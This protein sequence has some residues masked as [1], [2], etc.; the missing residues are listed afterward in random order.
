MTVVLFIPVWPTPAHTQS[1]SVVCLV[2]LRVRVY[3]WV[4]LYVVDRVF[5]P[6][7]INVLGMRLRVHFALEFDTQTVHLTLLERASE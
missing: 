1:Q 2:N 5:D 6:I 3:P 7:C 4:W